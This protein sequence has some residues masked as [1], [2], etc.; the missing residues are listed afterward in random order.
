MI[1]NKTNGNVIQYKNIKQV[2]YDQ[3]SNFLIKKKA[4]LIGMNY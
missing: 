1:C 4:I 2:Y 3:K